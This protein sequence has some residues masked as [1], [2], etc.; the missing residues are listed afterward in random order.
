MVTILIANKIDLNEQVVTSEEG[1]MLSKQLLFTQFLETS[2]KTNINILSIITY[3]A[4]I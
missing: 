4:I 1:F 3:Y 2:A